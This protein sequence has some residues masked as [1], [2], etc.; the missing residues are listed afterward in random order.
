[1][2]IRVR[3]RA[4]PNDASRDIDLGPHTGTVEPLRAKLARLPIDEAIAE[5]WR[6]GHPITL[7]R[8]R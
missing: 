6:R 2:T 4:R 7:S 3:D 1:M 8:S 5:T